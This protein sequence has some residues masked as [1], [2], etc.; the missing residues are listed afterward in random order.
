MERLTHSRSSGIKTGYWSP[1]VKET[2]VQR[3][4]QYEN[5]GLTPDEIR[6]MR[7]RE[8]T[9][10][11]GMMEKIDDGKEKALEMT[12]EEMNLSLRSF[13]CLKRAGINTVGDLAGKSEDEMM[14]IRNLGRRCLEEIT[15]ELEALGLQLNG[16]ESQEK[17]G[18]AR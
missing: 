17:K 7:S 11:E 3:L 4:A 14:R 9:S 15:A 16:E 13:N 1:E 18:E 8:E 5:T 12:L 6:E 10:K 2:L